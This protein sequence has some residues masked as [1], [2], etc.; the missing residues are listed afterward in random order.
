MKNGTTT[1]VLKGLSRIS[2]GFR[3]KIPDQ[4]GNDENLRS[5]MTIG[6]AACLIADWAA[7]RRAIG[8]RN[9]EQ[10]T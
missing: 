4:V 3:D 2:R 9:G 8:T 7:A 1:F 5:G 10:L 6:Y